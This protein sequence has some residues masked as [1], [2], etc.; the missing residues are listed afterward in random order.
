[1]RHGETS[2]AS[3]MGSRR[4]RRLVLGGLA[5][6]VLTVAA[7]AYATAE[8]RGRDQPA[9]GLAAGR[10]SQQNASSAADRT[11][12]PQAQPVSQEQLDLLPQSDVFTSIP[13][14][15][16]DPAPGQPPTGMMA[17]PIRTVAAY[18]APGG[19]PVAAVPSTQLIGIEPTRARVDTWLPV[20]DRQPGWVMVALPSRP[21]NSVAWL[22]VEPPI[23]FTSTPYLITVDRSS[24]TMTLHHHDREIGRWTVGI[25][26]PNSVTPTGR[27]FMVAVIRDPAATYSPVLVVLGAH[28]D[29]YTTY[30]GG[31]GTIGIHGWPDHGVFGTASSDGCVRVPAD[32]LHAVTTGNDGQP[33]PAG[34]AVVIT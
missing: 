27:T 11:A 31:P 2:A 3:H 15:P 18:T 23:T 24:F 4:S 14:A 29:T 32:A 34:T 26:A 7:L 8:D 22:A 17:H 16:R 10:Q 5:L 12:T 19:D 13:A 9:P 28:S 25:G 30:G 33:I 21:N 6:S 1:M 20:L